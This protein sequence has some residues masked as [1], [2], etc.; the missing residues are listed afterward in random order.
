[1]KK[2]Y[3]IVNEYHPRIETRSFK[4]SNVLEDEKGLYAEVYYYG[5]EFQDEIVCKTRLYET[6]E[7]AKKYLIVQ[8]ERKVESLK[9]HLEEWE[10][11]LKELKVQ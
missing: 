4:I 6:E 9:L 10:R 7:E 11:K 3:Y 8:T 5:S 2:E 1:M